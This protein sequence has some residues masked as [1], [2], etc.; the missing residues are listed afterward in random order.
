ME[1]QTLKPVPY[2]DLREYLNLLEENGLLKRVR[3]KVRLKHEI[4]AICA[5]SLDK[6][7]P[8]L[9]FENID[10][11]EGM[12][13]VSNIISTPAQL[14]IAFGT[15]PIEDRIYEKII[16]GMKVRTPCKTVSGGPCKENIYRGDQVDLYR[17]PTPYWHELDGGAYMGTAAGCIT[18]DP[19]TGVLNV[20][21]YRCMIQDK[22]TLSL[23]GGVRGQFRKQPVRASTGP[24][25]NDSGGDHILCNEEQGLP[26]PIAIVL[27]M[28]PLLTLAS[29]TSVPPDE[30]GEA[31]YGAAGTW[32]GRP[33][34]VAKCETS[35]LLIPAH[36]EIVL[37]G[38]VLP[39]ARTAEGPHGESTG[40]YGENKQAFV[41]RI[42][43]VTH[44]DRP[45]TYGIICRLIEDYPRSLLRSGSLQTLLIR[46]T[47]K[48]NI[49]QVYF[50]EVGR[51]GM[52]I[53]AADIRHPQEPR[54]IMEA[55]W[56]HTGFRWIIV[57]DGDCDVRNWNEVMWRVCSAAEPEQD[58]ITGRACP[59]VRR[60][61]AEIDFDPPSRGMGID[62]TMR[63]KNKKFPP[64]NSVS[65][66]LMAE[67]EAKW[68]D[69]GLS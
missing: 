55:A 37:E 29:G 4:G 62:A 45:I 52:L 66:E 1:N 68:R 5:R 51:A 21:T 15:D 44:R 65:K 6:N 3:A 42:D 12:K 10:G 47:L 11:Y 25:L 58:V 2:I 61:D 49:K 46:K 36:A 7:G 16:T 14:G 40:F 59:A 56:E 38:E 53:V 13:L 27:G 28:D 64:I 50:P 8:A 26:T 18:R 34:E 24:T 9:F 20:G 39:R 17:F 19:L 43:C 30:S 67:V 31:E 41:V 57:V 23:A 63:F 60:P 54:E 48:D 32:R 69:Y 35:D 22:T 33:T